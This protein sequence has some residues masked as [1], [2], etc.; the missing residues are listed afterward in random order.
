M[1][2]MID[3]L[4]FLLK[5]TNEHGVHS[6]FLFAYLTKCLYRGGW[7]YPNKALGVAMKSIPYFG[8]ESVGNFPGNTQ[9]ALRLAKAFPEKNTETPPF[10]LL[11]LGHPEPGLPGLVSGDRYYHDKTLCVIADIHKNGR[12]RANWEAVKELR[13]ARVTVDAYYF[14]LVFFRDELSRQHFRIR[15]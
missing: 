9:N 5:S 15:I 7:P 11:M 4:G 10:D 3:Y 2:R 12:Y 8:I 14:G 6:P 1:F 13:H